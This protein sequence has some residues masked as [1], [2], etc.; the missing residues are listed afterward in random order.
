MTKELRM[1]SWPV[2]LPSSYFTGFLMINHPPVEGACQYG[3]GEPSA[4]MDD[5]FM[6]RLCDYYEKRV[7]SEPKVAGSYEWDG[8]IAT[9][10]EF[11][12]LLKNRDVGKLHDYLSNMFTKS[13]TQG[14]AQGQFFYDKLRRD[15]DEIQKNT[16][17]AIYDKFLSLM[18][19]NAIIPT[20]SPEDY[21]KRQDFLKFYTIDP[22]DY[23]DMLE[24]SFDCDLKAPEFQGGHFGIQT[25]RHG[26][27]SDRDIMALSIAIKVKQTYWDRKDIRIA[28]LGGGVG[29][30]TYWLNKLGFT[31][32]T[33]IDLPTVTISAMYFLETNDIT[34]TKFVSSQEFDG[35]FDL[36]IN[37]D[38]LT[39]YSKDAAETYVSKIEEKAGHFMS[40]NRE[41]DEFRVSDICK[42]RRISRNQFWLRR[43]YIEE[44]YVPENA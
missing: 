25:N 19:A 10:G 43:G 23:M 15:E 9:H 24:R 37:I 32:I 20:F 42:M 18:E 21:Q 40:I 2:R 11:V 30:L 26:L 5:D 16:G 27:Y 7:A 39:Q 34:N 1:M 33:Y 35:D 4:V 29:H 3:W 6:N 14:T 12:E 41:F 22:D 13:L 31:D 17:F 8:I 44:D 36:V 28:D 38:G